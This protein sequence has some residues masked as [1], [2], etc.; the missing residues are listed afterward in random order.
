METPKLALRFKDVRMDLRSIDEHRKIIQSD[1]AVWWGWWMKSHEFPHAPFLEKKENSSGSLLLINR[2]QK[3]C[4]ICRY[5]KV[6]HGNWSSKVLDE[7]RIPEYYRA[8]KLKIP[9]FFLLTSIDDADFPEAIA[10]SFGDSTMLELDQDGDSSNSPQIERSEMS[11]PGLLILSDIHF[12]D[13]YAFRKASES[14]KVGD[15]RKTL[16]ESIVLDLEKAGIKENVGQVAILGDFTTGGNWDTAQ[17]EDILA[18]FKS[19]FS[20]LSLSKSHCIAI[21]GNHD[22]V[23]YPAE[24][25]PN[26][27]I[28]AQNMQI[29]SDHEVPFRR[30]ISELLD[31]HWASPLNYFKRFEGQF[32]DVVICALNSCS[33]TATEWTEY[34]YVGAKGIDVLEAVSKLPMLKP[35]YKFMILHHHLLP[36]YGVEAPRKNGVS[37]TLDSNELLS[38][39]KNAGIHLAIHGHQHK[40]HALQ[41]AILTQNEEPQ[42]ITIIASGSAGCNH[43]WLPPDERNTYVYLEMTGSVCKILIREFL[44][45]GGEGRTLFEKNLKFLNPD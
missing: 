11:K 27:D 14:L 39:A 43:S 44:T 20:E 34:G 7:N 26:A 13:F 6:V 8:D 5:I 3:T 40:S 31:R 19:I 2:D 15:T 30:F 38:A 35:T 32:F 45:N 21:P 18:E 42:P 9:A 41:Y 16:C 25:G 22:I 28:V 17:R 12:G 37:L 36:V 33:I 24:G 10:T 23:R 4:Y 29:A 1:A